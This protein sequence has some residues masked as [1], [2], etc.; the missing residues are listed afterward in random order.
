MVT[1]TTTRTTAA[2]RQRRALGP[3]PSAALRLWPPSTAYL[4]L[5]VATLV[6]TIALLLAYQAKRSSIGDSLAGVERGDVVDLSRVTGPEAVEAA[7]AAVVRDRADRQ[8]T[9]TSIHRFLTDEGRRAPEADNVGMLT[10]IRVTHDEARRAGSERLVARIE[11]TAPGASTVQLLTT[12]EITELKPT[13]VVSG[14]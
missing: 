8:F 3:R 9:A 5:C 6:T 2:D 1:A 4:A 13:F 7:L 14:P 12:S 11:R 10:R